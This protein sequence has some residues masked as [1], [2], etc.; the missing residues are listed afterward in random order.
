MNNDEVKVGGVAYTIVEKPF[1]EVDGS[2]DYIGHCS[3]E[4]T[5]I[6]VLEDLSQER[7]S[8]VIVHELTHA[9]F[10]EAGYEEQDEDMINRIGKILH[11]VIIDNFD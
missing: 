8:D 4:N 9:I 3:F 1:I 6:A 11:Q 2:R 10:Y 7:K 5:E